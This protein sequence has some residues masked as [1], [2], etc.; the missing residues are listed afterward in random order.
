M[1]VNPCEELPHHHEEGGDT[2]DREEVRGQEDGGGCQRV[3]WWSKAEVQSQV[4]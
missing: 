2:G 4:N 1:S 3:Y